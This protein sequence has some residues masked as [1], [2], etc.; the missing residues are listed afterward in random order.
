MTGGHPYEP[1]ELFAIFDAMPHVRYEHYMFWEGN[2]K[3]YDV[4]LCYD[5]QQ[6]EFT[7]A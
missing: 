7:P 5:M 4:V 3:H 1:G 2:L 6:G